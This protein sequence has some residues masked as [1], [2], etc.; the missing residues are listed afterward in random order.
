[1]DALLGISRAIDWINDKV[2]KIV[3]W[4]VLAAVVVSAGNALIR[5]ALNESSNAWL[6][7]Q[8]Y[9]FSAVFLLCAGY[10]LLNNQHIRIDI[11]NHRL[12]HRSRNWIDVIGHVFFLIPLCILVLS[13][14]WPYFMN[15][16]ESGEMSSN[17]GGL[18]R[19]PA[20]LLIVLGFALLLA[21]AF[22]EL[23]KRVAVMLG[24]IPD[25]YADKEDD[26][27]L[28]PVLE[29]EAGAKE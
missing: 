18:I 27:T 11:V 16:Y 19:W 2:G 4:L 9:M 7:L 25:P 29:R 26:G 1:M 13:E 20:R 17:A 10:T 21:Q 28:L 15:A 23:I 14:G 12:S 22:S 3:Y 8:W 24:R 6:E 5:Y